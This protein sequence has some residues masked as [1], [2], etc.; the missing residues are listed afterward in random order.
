MLPLV[1]SSSSIVNN[2]ALSVCGILFL[3]AANYLYLSVRFRRDLHRFRNAKD[4][5]CLPAPQVPS[6][7]PWLGIAPSFLTTKPLAFWTRLFEWYP[8]DAGAC[9]LTMGGQTAN[10]IF[11]APATHFIMKDRKLARN[12][13]TEMVVKN[14]FGLSAEDCEKFCAFHEKVKPGEMSALAYLEKMNAEYLLKT[15][16]VNELTAEFLST[17]RK[18]ISHIFE[19]GPGEVN[20]YEWQR[21][22]MFTAST[23]AF[24]SPPSSLPYVE[25]PY[26]FS[27]TCRYECTDLCSG[28]TEYCKL[29]RTSKKCSSLSIRTC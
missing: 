22:L 2:I 23:T 14:G 25:I 24:V 9:R 15:E 10:V 11:N 5:E 20:L 18:Q 3:L 27:R 13:F 8:R 6:A 26:P 28:V 12:D 4:G 17:M 16:R 21:S 29:S 1:F 19:D 7:I